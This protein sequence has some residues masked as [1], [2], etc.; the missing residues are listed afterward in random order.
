MWESRSQ[1]DMT[2]NS[3]LFLEFLFRCQINRYDMVGNT[4]T[5]WLK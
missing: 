5:F 3:N 1:V 2:K 4:G